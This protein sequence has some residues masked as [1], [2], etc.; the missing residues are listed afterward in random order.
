[1]NNDSRIYL[2][3]TSRKDEKKWKKFLKHYFPNHYASSLLEED[4]LN[5]R[6]GVVPNGFGLLAAMCIREG[7][8][9]RIYNFIE[10]K[11]TLCYKEILSNGVSL[12]KGEPLCVHIILKQR[13]AI[14]NE[15]I[16]V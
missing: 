7:G 12:S 14:N 8:F 3:I 4:L 13:K 9:K 10:F 6:I 5:R 16:S 15:R 2:Y 1:M 11:K